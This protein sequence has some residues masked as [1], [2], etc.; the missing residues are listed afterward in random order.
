MASEG[1]IPHDLLILATLEEVDYPLLLPIAT[2][3]GAVLLGRLAARA[4]AIRDSPPGEDNSISSPVWFLHEASRARV[5]DA[6]NANSSLYYNN[7]MRIL[8][9]SAVTC[10]TPVICRDVLP[11]W[12]RYFNADG[13]VDSANIGLLVTAPPC[14]LLR[15]DYDFNVKNHSRGGLCTDCAA[16]AERKIDDV[17]RTTWDHLPEAMGLENW[18]TLRKRFRMGLEETGAE[19][20]GD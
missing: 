20:R 5:L 16:L 9:V 13:G 8:A 7:L 4:A 14:C 17:L 10:T 11:S 1:H 2:H 15:D 19:Q 12:P 18:D 6:H 3:R